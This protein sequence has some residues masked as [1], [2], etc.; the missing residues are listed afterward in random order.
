VDDQGTD[1]VLSGSLVLVA[2]PIGNLG[3]LAPRAVAV[4]RDAQRI[5]CEDTRRTRALLSANGIGGGSRLVSLHEHNEASRIG[6][7]I[8]AIGEGAMV[9]VVS[10]AGMPAVSDPGQLLVAAVADAGLTITSVPGPSSVL[11]ALVVS[12]LATDR[13]VSEGFLPR[14]GAERV[15]RIGSLKHEQRTAVILES[16]KRLY[17][18]VSELEEA[19]DPERIVVVARELTKLHEEIWRGTLREAAARFDGEEVKGEVVIVLA[20]AEPAAAQPVSDAAI[21]KFVL[22]AMA[23]GVTRRD[24]AHEAAETFSV[25]KRRAYEI[26]TSHGE[27]EPNA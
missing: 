11:A 3:D 26:A 12:G 10:D 20:G 23:D 2:T 4:L 1:A 15:A 8:R 25:S 7:A 24:A 17:A 14:K 5:Y 9:A 13:F 21:R 22:A 6:E 18:T 19:L 27:N 16:P